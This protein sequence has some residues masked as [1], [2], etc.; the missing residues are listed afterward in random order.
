MAQLGGGLGRRARRP[1]P[2]PPDADGR[3]RDGRPRDREADPPADPQ[4]KDPQSAARTVCLNLLT[5]RART[6]AELSAELARRGFDDAVAATVL[7]RLVE[8]RLL[9][10]T[11][12][13]E[14]WVDSRHRHRGLGR[15][16]LSQELRR[17]GVDAETAD[18]AVAGLDADAERDKARELVRRR[19]PSLDRVEP[20][21]AA[22]RLVGMLA[23]K[24]YGAGL[25]YEVV[26][27]EMAARGAELDEADPDLEDAD[28]VAE[29][30]T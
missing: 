29:T 12:F 5:T 24:G 26:R 30:H 7:D 18:E 25:S 16:A 17:K 9:D 28:P 19:L 23:R 4:S 10:D 22:R 3:T 15:R 27:A 21:A 8:V 14:Q 2:E 13:A 1:A 20:P 6:R 11:A